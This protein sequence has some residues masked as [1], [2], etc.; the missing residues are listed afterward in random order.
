MSPLICVVMKQPCIC[1]WHQDVILNYLSTRLGIFVLQSVNR[2]RGTFHETKSAVILVLPA[3]LYTILICHRHLVF[4]YMWTQYHLVSFVF[5]VYV[6][7]HYMY[8]FSCVW[9]AF[10]LNFIRWYMLL[11]VWVQPFSQI[12]AIL[13]SACVTT[14]LSNYCQWAPLLLRFVCS[15]NSCTYLLCLR[16]TS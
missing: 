5:E 14:Y 4:M 13:S 16:I 3:A 6:T 2:Q 7:S 10:S 9:L 15:E 12:Y 1:G 8:V 11:V